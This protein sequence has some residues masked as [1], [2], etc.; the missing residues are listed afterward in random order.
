[1]V[2][3]EHRHYQLQYFS[4]KKGENSL[5][6]TT[7]VI[8]FF[9]GSLKIFD[10]YIVTISTFI[11]NLTFRPFFHPSTVTWHAKRPFYPFEGCGAHCSYLSLTSPPHPSRLRMATEP[12]GVDPRGDPPYYQRGPGEFFPR[13][14]WG[15][16]PK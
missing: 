2:Q 11:P 14:G 4:N 9:I 16:A 6:N 8:S 1:M 3:H 13:E 7:K 5:L 12:V 15:R 10:P